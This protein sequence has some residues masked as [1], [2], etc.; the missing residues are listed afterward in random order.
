MA[1]DY[2]KNPLLH[3]LIYA[4][5]YNCV[6]E[7]AKPLGKIL[8]YSIQNLIKYYNFEDYNNIILMPVPLHYKRLK[9][10]GFNQAELL[11]N[12]INQQLKIP[13]NN[14]ILERIR[15]TKPQME[16][17]NKKEREI[18]IKN[19]FTLLHYNGA[20]FDIKNKTIIL[21]DDI[22]TTGFTLFE[23]AKALKPLKPKQILGL[24]LAK[25]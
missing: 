7:L 22:S 15:N 25:G 4:Y 1:A 19:A 12:E 21:V 16:I 20:R 3:K 24:V 2:Q 17:E 5:K 6:K 8:S 9:W 11:I 14:I 10:R 18:N 23:C 13:V